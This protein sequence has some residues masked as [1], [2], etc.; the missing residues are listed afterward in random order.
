M[1][2]F[3]FGSVSAAA[4]LVAGVAFASGST[5]T[6]T[7]SGINQVANV[8]QVNSSS[9]AVS[10][11]TQVD[12]YNNAAVTQGGSGN[13][14][15][16]NQ[17]QGA[18]GAIHSPSNNSVSDQEGVNSK[19]TVIQKGNSSSNVLQ[20]GSANGEHAIVFQQNNDSTASIVQGGTNEL[21]LV[22]QEE[23][24]GNSASIVQSG[25]GDGIDLA[26]S[27]GP[28]HLRWRE[29]LPT[30]SPVGDT[31]PLAYGPDGATIDQVGTNN[32]GAISQQGY[33]NFADVAQGDQGS[34]GVGNYGSIVQGAGQYY[35]DGVIYQQGNA[36]TATIT[37]IGTGSSY[38]TVWQ[39]GTSNQGYSA[40]SGYSDVS[41][42]EQGFV[43]DNGNSGAPTNNEFAVVNQSGANESSEV[44]QSGSFNTAYVTQS[45]GGNASL[46][47]QSGSGNYSN[48]VQ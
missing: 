24:T 18:Y 23:G 30:D 20:N 9:G 10:T 47:V 46:V 43:D 14:A 28:G 5:S 33:L 31:L 12:G 19:V 41:K 27:G 48:V 45:T 35:T 16:I 39:N 11:I 22:N 25:T 17:S 36:N 29:H 21:G 8:N 42:I 38:S 34:P 44:R 37:Q 13:I 7:Q 3:I 1:K 26:S 15:S 4:L 32:I 6:V 2:S 40:Q